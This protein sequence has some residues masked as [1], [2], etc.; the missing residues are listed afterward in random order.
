MSALCEKTASHAIHNQGDAGDYTVV[1][2]RMALQ[3][4]GALLPEKPAREQEWL[5]EEDSRGAE[6]FIEWF[7][8]QRMKELMET[9]IGDGEIDATDYLNG[10]F[11]S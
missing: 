3:E 10:S 8:G 11:N 7:S 2:V 5:Q 9:G 6:E 4:V 1:D